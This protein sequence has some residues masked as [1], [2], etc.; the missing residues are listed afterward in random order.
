MSTAYCPSCRVDLMVEANPPYS[1]SHRLVGDG[2]THYHPIS[3]Q[4]LTPV[5]VSKREEA[6]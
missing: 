4:E 3:G 1:A 5:P 6:Q 2:F